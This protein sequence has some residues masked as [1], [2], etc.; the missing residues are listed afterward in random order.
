MRPARPSA[1]TW[2]PS[3]ARGMRT[4]SNGNIPGSLFDCRRFAECRWNSRPIGESK[5][6]GAVG[7][8]TKWDGQVQRGTKTAEKLANGRSPL[9]LFLFAPSSAFVSPPKANRPLR[10]RPN[11][12]WQ[13]SPML[14]CVQRAKVAAA[15]LASPTAPLG[16]AFMSEWRPALRLLTPRRP[17]VR[18]LSGQQVRA[19]TV[20]FGSPF[21]M[22]LGEEVGGRRQ[23]RSVLIPALSR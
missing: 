9:C 11:A 3:T 5:T 7:G 19:L 23:S 10:L 13:R 4:S 22:F 21:Q 16:G 2:R 20:F 18:R 12:E 15:P 17:F 14:V 6:S 1:P 8:E